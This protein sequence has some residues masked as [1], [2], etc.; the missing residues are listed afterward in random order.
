MGKEQIDTMR[1]P[2]PSRLLLALLDRE[3]ISRLYRSVGEQAWWW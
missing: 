2:F 1:V 3:A